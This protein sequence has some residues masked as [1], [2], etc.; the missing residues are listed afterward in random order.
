M[1]K[2]QPVRSILCSRKE[3][4]FVVNFVT[5]TAFLLKWLLFQEQPVSQILNNQSGYISG[6]IK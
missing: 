6:N 4:V 1:M 2:I 5:M 3:A